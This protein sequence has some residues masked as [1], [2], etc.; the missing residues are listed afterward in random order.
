MSRFAALELGVA[1]QDGEPRLGAAAEAERLAGITE[2]Q[3]G[4]LVVVPE[5]CGKAVRPA[6]RERSRQRRLERLTWRALF[7]P[8]NTSVDRH[9]PHGPP[10]PLMNKLHH[11]R[12][13]DMRPD[14]DLR[15]FFVRQGGKDARVRT[16]RTPVGSRP[17]SREQEER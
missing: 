10:R 6:R 13:L 4:T 15:L 1:R 12:R 2:E 9:P 3:P 7:E 14:P 8:G 17:A 16:Y 11:A 5:H